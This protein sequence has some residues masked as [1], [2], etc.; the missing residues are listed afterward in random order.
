LPPESNRA[1]GWLPRITLRH[2]ADQ[3]AGF[4]KPGGYGKVQFEPGTKWH[5]SDA[6]PNWLAECLTLA[7]GRDLNDVMFERV[8]TP[9][10][11]TP[12]DIR[13]RPHAYRPRELAGVAR[14]EF[15]S[16][17]HANVQAMARL[18]YLYLREGRWREQQIIPADFVRLARAPAKERRPGGVQ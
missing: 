1:T 16:G 3:T 15:G 14:R 17:F 9:I 11:I 12:Q 13:W 18:G 4:E 5:Y 8:F 10:G 6:G 2:L 7:Y